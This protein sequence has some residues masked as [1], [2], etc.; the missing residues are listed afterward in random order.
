MP[1]YLYFDGQHEWEVIKPISALDNPEVCDLC[2]KEGRR[3]LQAPAIDRSAAA[4]W[5]TQTWHPSLGC[6]TRSNLHARQIA[7]SRGLEEVGNEKPETIHKH[8]EKQREET[9]ER[10]WQEAT[11]EKLY[12]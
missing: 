8:F 2:G 3:Q 5:N 12:D 1:T 4:D 7:K 9:R 10:R 6:Y 11:R